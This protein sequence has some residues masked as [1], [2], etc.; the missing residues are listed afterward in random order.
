MIG[1][2]VLQQNVDAA[3]LETML[4]LLLGCDDI[5]QQLCVL[6]AA[7]QLSSE[8]VACLLREAI[9][10]RSTLAIEQLCSLAAAQQMSRLQIVGLLGAFA[11]GDNSTQP[12]VVCYCLVPIFM[13]PAVA[14]PSSGAVVEFVEAVLKQEPSSL[15]I[16]TFS[17]CDP[18][19][20]AIASMV[21]H[22]LGLP[23]VVRIRCFEAQSALPHTPKHPL[24]FRK[25]S[26]D[27]KFLLV[28]PSDANICLAPVAAVEGSPV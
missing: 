7:G 3:T 24:Q 21:G 10:M 4:T 15:D 18:H 27:G 2:L 14:A 8:A 28:F 17:A 16:S 11:Q 1:L 6:P 23:A 22:L 9:Q 26:G 19:S 5:T 25:C 12:D 13:L 20:I